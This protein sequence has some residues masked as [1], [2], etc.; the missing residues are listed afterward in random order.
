MN[1]FQSLKETNMTILTLL[2]P[3]PGIAQK[4][5]HSLHNIV[6]YWV[7]NFPALS[8]LLYFDIGTGHKVTAR[9]GRREK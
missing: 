2:P 3:Q 1:P 5:A 8:V 6:D 4:N 7:K 9:V